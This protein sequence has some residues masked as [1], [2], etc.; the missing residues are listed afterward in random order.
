MHEQLGSKLGLKR[1]GR[2]GRNP[3]DPVPCGIMTQHTNSQNDTD[4]TLR[5]E[6]LS[7]FE[8]DSQRR[9]EEAAITSLAQTHLTRRDAKHWGGDL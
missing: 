2:R 4:R 9:R 1:T 8:E 5:E 6:F 3:A 7:Q